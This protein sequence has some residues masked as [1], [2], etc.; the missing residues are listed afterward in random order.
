ML[1]KFETGGFVLRGNERTT[2]DKNL[3]T[4]GPESCEDWILNFKLQRSTGRRT[5]VTFSGRCIFT[6]VWIP[7]RVV[8]E[9]S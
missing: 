4:S 9:R 3:L 1:K 2:E 6:A 7:E 8:R 5:L